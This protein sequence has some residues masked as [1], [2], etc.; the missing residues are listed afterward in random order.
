MRIAVLINTSW[1]IYNFRLELLRAL[2][3]K[4]HNIICI[5]PYDSY[6]NKLKEEGFEYYDIKINNK[7]T[8]PFED[9]KL[10]YDYYRLFKKTKPDVVLGYT[11]KPNIYGSIAT[12][13]LRIPTISNITGLGTVFL[14]K[15]FSSK[16][17]K[18]LYKLA[19]SKNK[20]FFQ[21]RDDLNIFLKQ[22][23]VKKGN[24]DLLPGSGINLQKFKPIPIVKNNN[25]FK[26]LLIARLI[27]DK[28]VLEYV[29]AARMIKKIYTNVNFLIIGAIWLDNPSAIYVDELISWQREGI[30]DYLGTTDNI[31]E[32]IS[33]VDCVVLPSYREGTP[34]TL[35]EAASMAKPIIATNV[36]G[37]REVVDDGVNGFLCRVRDY[38]DLAKSM[39]KMINLPE[40][41]R[42]IM[43]QNGRKKMENEFDEKFV[44]QKYLNVLEQIKLDYRLSIPYKKSSFI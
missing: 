21:N 8:N 2:K 19:L 27:K 44:I 24:V 39:E 17:A 20:V 36:A 26:F 7:G 32:E 1:N 15:S 33:K 29:N 41:D 16:L 11:I 37:C 4:G 13:F 38:K 34:R 22:K 31:K 30:I 35:L 3:A 18:I 23:L 6:S 43:G 42:I 5:A 14:K 10:I 12:G 25:Q 40:K 9:V 28:G